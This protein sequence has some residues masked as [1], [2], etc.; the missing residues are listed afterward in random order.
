METEIDLLKKKQHQRI[1]SRNI[2]SKLSENGKNEILKIRIKEL[3]AETQQKINEN[4]NL[5]N[6]NETLKKNKIIRRRSKKIQI[7]RDKH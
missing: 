4:E 6:Q 1:R 5:K 3:E 2:K 7:K